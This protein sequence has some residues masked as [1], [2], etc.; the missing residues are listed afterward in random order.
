VRVGVGC[1]SSGRA[2]RAVCG[3]NRNGDTDFDP[4]AAGADH[5]VVGRPITR[6][7]DPIAVIEA[8]QEDITRALA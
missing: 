1:L 3:C 8:M 7:D 6:A 5:L 2:T 4:V